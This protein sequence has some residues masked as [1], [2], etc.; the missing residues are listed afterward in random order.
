MVHSVVLPTT[1]DCQL[2]QRSVQAAQ[3]V[4]RTFKVLHAA[5]RYNV[6]LCSIQN[7]KGLAHMPHCQS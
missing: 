4:G 2:Y 7:L 3:R 6:Q 5:H 1:F